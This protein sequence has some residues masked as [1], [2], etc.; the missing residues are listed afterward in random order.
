MYGEIADVNASVEDSVSGVRVVQSFTN[1]T[2]EMNR[3]STNN[4]RFRK[5][6]LLGY[7]VMSFTHYQAFT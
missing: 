4:R 7:K 5:A 6:K 2:Y 3:F 1:E